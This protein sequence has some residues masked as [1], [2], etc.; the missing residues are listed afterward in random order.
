MSRRRNVIFIV[1][2]TASGK[3]EISLYLARAFNGE[4]L[5]ADSMQVYRDM[6]I[7]TDKVAAMHRRDVPHHLIDILDCEQEYSVFDFRSDALRCIAEIVSRGTLPFVVGGSGLYIRALTN[8]LSPFPGGA[9]ELRLAL[10]KRVHDEGLACL[11][12]ELCRVAPERAQRIHPNDQRRITRALEIHYQLAAAPRTTRQQNCSLDELGYRYRMI[13]ITAERKDLYGRVNERVDR[14]VARG[15][16]DEVA[17]VKGRLSA[18]T[19]QAVGYKE[20]IAFFDGQC[21]LEE[22]I[23]EI[24][25]NTRHLVK[26]QLTW[27]RHEPRLEWFEQRA[28]ESLRDLA[29]RIEGMLREWLDEPEI[30]DATSRNP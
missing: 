27:F 17:R 26:K 5:S 12:A 30:T 23:D 24:K 20:L 13:G 29:A 9:A 11:H 19:R 3:T 4:I 18:T 1:G 6:N 7:G 8:G 28:H 25:K 15:L 21:T 2:P 22:A 16:V 14:M 10:Q